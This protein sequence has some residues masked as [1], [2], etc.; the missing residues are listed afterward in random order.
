MAELRIPSI[1]SAASPT[2][3]TGIQ[4]GLVLFLVLGSL[5]IAYLSLVSWKQRPGM[6]AY[7]ILALAGAVILY[8]LGYCG[9]LLSS[10][11]ASMLSFVRIEYLGAANLPALWLTLALYYANQSQWITPKR[12]LFLW[13]I[14]MVT[15]AAVFT[16]S[17]HHF[18]YLTTG[19]AT[20][21][22]FPTFSFVR[23]PLYWLNVV[24]TYC[25]FTLAT[26]LLARQYRHSHLLYRR[27]ATLMLVASLVT[28]LITM[29]RLV[30]TPPIPGLDITPFTLITSCLIMGWGILRY[31]MIG[32]TPVA[33]DVLFE[34]QTDGVLVLDDQ[35]QIVDFNPAAREILGLPADSVGR[36]L[37]QLVS[38]EVSQVFENLVRQ[39]SGLELQIKHPSVRF[40]DITLTPLLRNNRRFIGNL[41][42]LHESTQRKEAQLSLERLNARLEE[43]IH[44]K[45]I[46]ELQLK[47]DATHDPLTSLPNRACFIERLGEAIR[48]IKLKHK[49]SFSVLFLDLDQFKI[50]NDS[51][52]HAYG[53]QLLI[54]VGGRL[55]NCLRS[56]DTIARLGGDEFVCLLENAGTVEEIKTVALR[57]EEVLCQ[58]FQLTEHKI[59]ISASIGIIPSLKGY[60]SS[61][62]VLR[63]ADIAMYR[64]KSLGKARFEFFECKHT[65]HDDGHNCPQS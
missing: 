27:Q 59:L 33:R 41:I 15:L 50:I 6:N 1:L 23:G 13:V 43:S 49:Q 53:D 55:S 57:I 58:P 44:Q 17:F 48:A 64:A 34:F 62:D 16:N 12:L 60:E 61:G 42:V 2:P 51:L 4:A 11:L 28:I 24:Y 26:V 46:A 38:E 9:E 19:V 10:D 20:D 52:G 63:D 39:Q 47:H 18:Y 5:V 32:I 56:Q 45:E 31:Q 25:S 35:H 54:A 40:F 3:I 7:L 36:S 30:F 14:P 22:S 8:A 65:V 37:T 21:G 29:L